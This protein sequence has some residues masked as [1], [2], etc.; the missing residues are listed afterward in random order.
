MITSVIQYI[1]YF[2][3]HYPLKIILNPRVIIPKNLDTKKP[4]MIIANHNSRIDPFLLALVPFSLIKQLIPIYFPTAE[5]YHKN[6]ILSLLLRLLGSYPI[7]RW[8]WSYGDVFEKT[9]KDLKNGKTTLIFPEAQIVKK[10]E[11]IEAKPGFLY[12][13]STTNPQIMYIKW[14]IKNKMTIIKIRKPKKKEYNEKWFKKE[15]Q[16][17][18]QEIDKM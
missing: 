9:I 14:I 1:Y 18:M 7:K 2:L 3:F 12:L 8:G 5:K 16:K 17:I 4:V 13:A 15:A 11:K 6:I 10:N